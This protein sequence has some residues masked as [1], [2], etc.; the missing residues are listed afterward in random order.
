MPTPA[1]TMKA[2]QD[3]LVALQKQIGGVEAPAT[4]VAATQDPAQ[5]TPTS[6]TMDVRAI[7]LDHGDSAV[8][9]NL[10]TLSQVI[11]K[12]AAEL[13][14]LSKGRSE[15]LVTEA[16]E[17]IQKAGAA[18]AKLMQI[19]AAL[20]VDPTKYEDDEDWKFRCKI[21]DAIS[22]LQQAAV[23]ERLLAIPGPGLDMVQAAKSDD[24][25]KSEGAKAGAKNEAAPTK[26][27]KDMSA[28]ADPEN[29]WGEDPKSKPSAA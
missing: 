7:A 24:V 26:W 10:T 5:Q 1:E 18:A 16:N 8:A 14:E 21:A 9:K 15:P 11:T 6:E 12:R 25:A 23:V 20:G 28:K 17:V 4:S 27:P 3:S 22:A 13:A 19:S 2:A 29:V